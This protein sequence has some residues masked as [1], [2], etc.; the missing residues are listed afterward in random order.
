M[1]YLKYIYY[2]LKKDPNDYTGVE[3]YIREQVD[4][5]VPRFLPSP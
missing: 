3:S 2:L 1:S 4:S 5:E